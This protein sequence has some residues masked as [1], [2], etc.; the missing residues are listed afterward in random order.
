MCAA[1]GIGMV[2]A[3]VRVAAGTIWTAIAAHWVFNAM[4]FV[5]SG[6]VAETLS[7][8]VEMQFVAAGVV[9]TLIGLGLV[10]LASRR[11]QGRG[12]VTGVQTVGVSAA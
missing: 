4:S 3:A 10:A 9:L 7:P 8:G 11:V 6:G 1:V 12:E 5:G 2:L